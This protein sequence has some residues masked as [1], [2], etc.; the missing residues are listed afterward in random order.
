LEGRAVARLTDLG[1]GG[2]LRDLFRADEEG[3]PI[4]AE[5]PPQLAAACVQVLKEWGWEQ[6]PVAVAW[7]P[8]VSRPRLVESLATGIATVGR[9]TMLG[10]LTPSPGAQELSGSTNSAFR[11]RDVWDRFTVPPGL[12]QALQGLAG[13]VLL[14]DDL[15]DSRWTMTVAGMALRRAGATGVMPFTL[16]SVG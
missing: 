7:V 12:K 16:A 1:W 6:R 4:D 9:L 2:A 14:V 5:L 3:R 13:P 10:P 15:V 11:V 8:S